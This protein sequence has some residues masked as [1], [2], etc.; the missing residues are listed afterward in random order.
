ME[1]AQVID[2]SM[3]SKN[4]IEIMAKIL[5]KHDKHFV[6]SIITNFMEIIFRNITILEDD[7]NLLKHSKLFESIPDIDIDFIGNYVDDELIFC[8]PQIAIYLTKN[9]FDIS[10]TDLE[11][12]IKYSWSGYNDRNCVSVNIT[13]TNGN[14]IKTNTDVLKFYKKDL[15]YILVYICRYLTIFN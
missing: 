12:Y 2:K 1:H 10:N 7:R 8:I 3:V 6:E 9:K 5:S 4:F 15:V 14:V 11:T 13:D